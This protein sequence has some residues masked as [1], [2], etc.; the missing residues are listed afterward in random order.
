MS[1][2]GGMSSKLLDSDK[3][4]VKIQ[5]KE[6]VVSSPTPT[7][8]K[9]EEKNN[10]Q[11]NAWISTEQDLLLT[12]ALYKL[13]ANRVKVKKGELIGVAIE[14]IYRILENQT[15]TIL[16]ASVLDTYLKKHER[17]K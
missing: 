9:K 17:N 11:L 4:K 16:N 3:P 12:N 8:V 6:V 5:E 1:N 7:V 10:C 13:K 2:D 15:P 14:V